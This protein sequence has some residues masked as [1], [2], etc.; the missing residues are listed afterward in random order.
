MDTSN[1]IAIY[2]PIFIVVLMA[3]YA[4][5]DGMIW[6]VIRMKK[7][8]KGVAVMSEA[9]LQFVGK[10]CVVVTASSLGGGSIAGVV[11]A[12]DGNWMTV[13]SKN[14]T[15]MVNTDFIMRIQ[16]KKR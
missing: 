3:A 7:R 4:A 2:L 11:K 13:E 14:K 5:Y 12:V 9:L 8:R 16:E 6:H 15:N 1:Y 10:E